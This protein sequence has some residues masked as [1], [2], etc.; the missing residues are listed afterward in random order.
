MKKNIAVIL[1][2][3]GG[4]E[5]LEQVKPYLFN[6]FSDKFI[7]T[8]P[9]IIRKMLAF[10]ISRTRSSKTKGIYSKIGGKSYS[11]ENTLNQANALEKILNSENSE[12]NFKTYICMSYW[13]PMH[14][15]V[16]ENLSKDNEKYCFEKIIHL[17]LYPQFS[18]TTTK[19]SFF[20]IEKE[21]EK[22]K[23]KNLKESCDH[24]FVCCYFDE[25][26]FIRAHAEI[27][28]KKFKEAWDVFEKNKVVDQLNGIRILFSAHS[29]PEKLTYEKEKGGSGDPY[30]FQ[31]QKTVELVMKEMK[32]IF[33]IIEFDFL[34]SYQS[35]IGPVKWLSPSTE[36][37][38][39]KC[40]RERLIPIIIP[41]AFVSDNSET[42]YELDI[43]YKELLELKEMKY[44]FRSEALNLDE[45]FLESLRQ[46]VF[47][48]TK[49]QKKFINSDDS[50]SKCDQKFFACPNKI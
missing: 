22:Q 32:K 10:L 43:E 21:L 26:N 44:F 9:Y 11:K 15:E 41:I 6:F 13:H 17:P 1:F 16:L 37:E 33:G 3:I 2:N 48:A 14:E 5:N 50:C 38:V 46:I 35:K 8:A 23:F 18:T 49:S 29:I 20:Y 36:D 19:S 12:Y 31:V 40:A 39:L 25:K 27:L 34:I 7:I 47:K 45:K 4:P 24:K 28:A 30:Q 42:L